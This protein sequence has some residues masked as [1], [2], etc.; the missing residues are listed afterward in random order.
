MSNP[1]NKLIIVEAKG[2]TKTFGNFT[3]VDHINFKVFQHECLGVLGPN[4]AGKTTT[5]R[6]LLGLSIPTAGELTVL[7][8]QLPKQG[9]EMRQEVGVVPQ[10]DNLDPDFTVIENL[11]AYANYFGIHNSTLKT[12]IDE[13][14]EFAALEKKKNNNVNILSGGMKRRLILARALI[15]QPQL[16]ILDEPT[17]GLDPHA[18]QMIWQRLAQLKR[19]NTS[20]ILTTHYMEEAERLC[21]RIIFIDKGKIIAEGKP[22]ELINRYVEPNVIEVFG[23]EAEAVYAYL[24]ALP[25]CHIEQVGETVFV[26]YRDE[27]AMLKEFEKWPHL[28]FFRRRANLEDV[29]IKLTGRRVG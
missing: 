12:R 14:L 18:R 28:D 23:E 27:Q 2:L 24:N 9:R 29:F 1:E 7:G 6:M 20:L 8:Y 11:I 3:A 26:Y 4:G 17:T 5:I 16:L 15:N 13:L 21:D 22:H 25:D 19:K 10:H